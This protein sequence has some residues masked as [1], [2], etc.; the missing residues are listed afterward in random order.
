M[1]AYIAKQRR[2][3]GSWLVYDPHAR[4]ITAFIGDDAELFMELCRR[5]DSENTQAEIQIIP[6]G[7]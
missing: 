1:L 5:R 6:K 4:E 7:E 2:D 3:G